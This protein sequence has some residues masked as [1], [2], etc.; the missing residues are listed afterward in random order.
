M[1]MDICYRL[2]V[3]QS[4]LDYPIYNDPAGYA[5]LILNGDRKTYSDAVTEYEPLD[6]RSILYPNK[7]PAVKWAIA[8]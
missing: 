1:P 2:V 4:E 6:N 3:P 7:N 8:L 5:D